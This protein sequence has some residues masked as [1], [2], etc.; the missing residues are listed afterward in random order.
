M[1]LSEPYVIPVSKTVETS[2]K[3]QKQLWPDILRLT[4]IT[5]VQEVVDVP[6]GGGGDYFR[7]KLGRGTLFMTK[8]AAKFP[9]LFMT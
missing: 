8:A 4:L 2:Q 9:T 6:G 7:K 3:Q 5:F 1:S